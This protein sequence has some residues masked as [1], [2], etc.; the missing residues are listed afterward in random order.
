MTPRLHTLR[1]Y[2]PTYIY[3]CSR[4]HRYARFTISGGVMRVATGWLVPT[5]LLFF[6]SFFRIVLPIL[7]NTVTGKML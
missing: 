3:G 7:G 6:L 2:M 4:G 5:C 1:T